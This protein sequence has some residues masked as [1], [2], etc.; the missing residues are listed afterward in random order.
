MKHA[1]NMNGE[2]IISECGHNSIWV[3]LGEILIGVLYVPPSESKY[4]VDDMVHSIDQDILRIT[5]TYSIKW[6]ILLG[7]FNARTT[8]SN[9]QIFQPE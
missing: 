3:L 8:S 2:E 1:V 7:D 5:N 4:N 9:D 6:C